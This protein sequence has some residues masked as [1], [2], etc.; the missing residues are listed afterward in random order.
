MEAKNF[1]SE[2]ESRSSG[3]LAGVKIL[4]MTRLLPGAYATALLA[5]LGAEVIKVERPGEGDPMRVSDVKIGNSS[6]FTWI[7]DRNKRSIALDLTDPDAVE[8]IKKL[9]AGCDIALESF[10][11]GVADR[12]GIGYEALSKVNPALVYCSITGYGQTGPLRDEPGHDLNY[13]GRAG[14][15]ATT[16]RDGEPVIPSIQVADLAGGA[17]F[18]AVGVLACLEGARRTGRGDHVDIS[19]TH[20]AFALQTIDI[21]GWLASGSVPKMGAGF[22]VGSVPCYQVYACADGRYLTVGALEPQFWRALCEALGRTDQLDKAFVPEAIADWQEFFASRPR[23]E[24][25]EMLD[26]VDTCVGP[27]NDLA[28]AIADP[29]LAHREAVVDIDGP[30]GKVGQVTSPIRL[31]ERDQTISAAPE[32][33]ADT[34]EVLREFGLSAQEVERMLESG[35]AAAG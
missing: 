13:I 22:L 17:L 6:A 31:R 23:D 35:A 34:V 1:G 10:R 21:A 26:G 27:V 7:T 11:P 24:W 5:D 8:A 29:Q 30:T 20:G 16:G 32:V 12:L 25:L 2:G 18:S 15:L 14:L 3:P 19:M 28:E 9:A 33:G 4:D